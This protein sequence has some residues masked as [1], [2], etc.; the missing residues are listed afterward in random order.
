MYKEFVRNNNRLP[1]GHVTQLLNALKPRETWISRNIINKAFIKF[2]E[3]VACRNKLSVPE[4]VGINSSTC[5]SSSNISDISNVSSTKSNKIGRPVGTTEAQ[6]LDKR[7][8]IIAAKNEIT[9]LYLL[10]YNEAKKQK[11]DRVERGTL[12]AIIND[13]KKRRKVEDNILTRSYQK[14]SSKELSGKS[15][16]SWGSN[17]ST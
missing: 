6:K 9:Q 16:S 12:L 5:N 7:K 2:R 15:S 4:S 3:D 1:Y 11:K 17:V 13:V 10:K 8:R 14:E